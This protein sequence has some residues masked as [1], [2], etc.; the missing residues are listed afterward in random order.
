MHERRRRPLHYMQ[1]KKSPVSCLEVYLTN[2][3]TDEVDS[4]LEAIAGCAV[5]P[6]CYL[7]VVE[8]DLSQIGSYVLPCTLLVVR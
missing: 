6:C 3:N 1:R 8:T 2:G 5:W 7:L 4:K